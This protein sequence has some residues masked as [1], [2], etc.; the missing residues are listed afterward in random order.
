M[1]STDGHVYYYYYYYH[2]YY[3]YR[4]HAVVVVSKRWGPLLIDL[5]A[6]NGTFVDGRRLEP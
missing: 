5:E 1:C 2:Y 3:H 4:Q 6:A